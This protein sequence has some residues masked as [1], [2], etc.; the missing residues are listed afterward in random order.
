MQESMVCWVPLCLSDHEATQRQQYQTKGH[1][2]EY[3][4]EYIANDGLKTL[5]LSKNEDSWQSCMRILISV[6]IESYMLA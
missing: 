6:P 3:D 1:W 2:T 5:Y 4:Q